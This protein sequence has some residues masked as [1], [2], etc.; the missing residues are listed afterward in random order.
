MPLFRRLWYIDVSTS[1][2]GTE[3][4]TSRLLAPTAGAL[5]G[6]SDSD[7]GLIEED[8]DEEAVAPFATCSSWMSLFS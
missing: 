4:S 7:Y 2:S 1:I 8:E 3:R 5:S 6:E